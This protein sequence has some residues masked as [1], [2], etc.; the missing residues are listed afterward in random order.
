MELGER[1][2]LAVEIDDAALKDLGVTSNAQ[3][4]LHSDRL[5]LRSLLNLL[6]R[7]ADCAARRRR[8]SRR[9]PGDDRRPVAVDARP[10]RHAHL[11]ARRAAGASAGRIDERAMADIVQQIVR[12]ERLGVREYSSSAI[13][14][15]PVSPSR[16]GLGKIDVVPAHSSCSNCRK[17]IARSRSCFDALS[18]MQRDRDRREPLIVGLSDAELAARERVLRALNTSTSLDVADAR[19]DET[20]AALAEQADVPILFDVGALAA[21]DAALDDTVSQTAHGISLRSQLDLLL[22]Y[23][24]LAFVIRDGAIHRHECYRRRA[25]RRHA[26]LPRGRP[27]RRPLRAEQL[28]DVVTTTVAPRHVD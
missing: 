8:A 18:R 20:I 12:P 17:S 6:V 19:L 21:D 9:H 14:A 11:P 3:V 22:R 27:G 25:G 28:L 26:A 7:Q 13:S 24:F 5:K 10:L 16:R 15:S 4:T 23:K 2:D 1:Y